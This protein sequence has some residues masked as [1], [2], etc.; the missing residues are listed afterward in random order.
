M[1]WCGVDSIIKENKMAQN[2]IINGVTYNNVPEVQIPKQGGGTAIFY[3]DSA[4][5]ITSPDIRNGK[6]GGTGTGI[7][8]GTMTEKS[9]ASYNPSTSDQVVSAD[10][11]L[12]GAQTFKAVTTTNL[13]A[14]YIAQGVTVK[15]G[16]VADDD[17]IA[18]VTGSLS[19]VVVSQDPGTK[20]LSIS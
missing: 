11:Y 20:V 5:D 2:V 19:S 13:N 12:A 3:D 15:V 1:E 9:A 6:K 7:I 4:A 14:S 16:C 8:T 18:S 17:C 10:Q